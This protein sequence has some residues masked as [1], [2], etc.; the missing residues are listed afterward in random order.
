MPADGACRA[1]RTLAVLGVLASCA[2]GPALRDG[3][4]RDPDQGWTIAAPAGAWTRAAAEGA[5]LAL[6]RDDGVAMSVT[7]RCEGVSAPPELLARQLGPGFAQPHAREAL[8]IAGAPAFAQRF[9]IER[10]GRALL[11]KT[12]TRATPRCVQ[13]FVLVTPA[14]KSDAEAVFDAWL[15]SFEEPR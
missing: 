7:S 12:V 11:I 2:S 13:D 14:G 10:A 15:A 1:V 8:E 5:D 9:E 3:S 6:R 4:Y